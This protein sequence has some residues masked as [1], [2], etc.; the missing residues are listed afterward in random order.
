A[1]A[2]AYEQTPP[3]TILL[4]LALK[5][6]APAKEYLR[7]HG[8]TDEQIA[9]LPVLQAV[10]LYEVAEYD[11]L[12]DEFLKWQGQPYELQRRGLDEADQKLKELVGRIGSPGLSLGG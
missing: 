12:F 2:S 6:Y 1:L 4:A 11:Q 8:R 9:A 7:R 3:K 5:N 10:F